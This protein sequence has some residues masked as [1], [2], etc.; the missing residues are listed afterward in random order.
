M[1]GETDRFGATAAG[2]VMGKTE[3]DPNLVVLLSGFL[4]GTYWIPLRSVE[5][6]GLSGPWASF[7]AV[8]T[9]L[10]ILA[11]FALVR[12]RRFMAGGRPLI[13]VGLLS[14]SAFMLYSDALLLT[15]VVTATLMFFLTPVWSTILGR[16]VLGQRFTLARLVTIALGLAGL[17]VILGA[18]GG[19]PLP[20]NMGDWLGLASGMVWAVASVAI[21]KGGDVGEVEYIF[22][23]LIGGVLMSALLPLVLMPELVWTI[24]PA[25][26]DAAVALPLL[27]GMAVVWFILAMAMLIWGN[28]RL[29]PGRVGILMMSEV[30]VTALTAA[31]LL[32]DE[33]FGWRQIVG[34]GLIVAAAAI[35]IMARAPEPALPP[36]PA[37]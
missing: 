13:A 24:E 11:P 9:G 26:I 12:W 10:I 7:G 31:V 1:A 6:A 3:L 14:G 20:R 37:E 30:L 15:E 33:P 8:V 4:W 19:L 2:E 21:R 35:D 34:G 22:A 5:A 25:A 32:D 36:E 29:D 18:D 27:A 23:Y 16:I 17:A 28:K